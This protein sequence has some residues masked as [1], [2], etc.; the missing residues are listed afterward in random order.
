LAPL[1][2]RTAKIKSAV[3]EAPANGHANIRP[4]DVQDPVRRDLAVLRKIGNERTRQN[5]DVDGFTLEDTVSDNFART[6]DEYTPHFLRFRRSRRAV[7]IT[8]TGDHPE[9]A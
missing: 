5:H 1:S 8:P 3:F 2:T 7:I 4:C 9:M 6:D